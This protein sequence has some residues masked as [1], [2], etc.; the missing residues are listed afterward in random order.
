[1][2]LHAL[3]STHCHHCFRDLCLKAL[4]GVSLAASSLI[5]QQIKT[6][7]ARNHLHSSV[8]LPHA[9]EDPVLAS[10]A[11]WGPLSTVMIRDGNCL[12][13]VCKK[14]RKITLS[15]K[16][17]GSGSVSLFPYKWQSPSSHWPGLE[18]EIQV[19]FLAR[20]WTLDKRFIL[21]GS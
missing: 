9:C 12:T 8:D 15:S 5:S 11:R 7:Q 18:W 21:A 1:M 10:W 3:S 19:H 2:A 4:C 20:Q 17:M 6:T 14:E 16:R 13:L